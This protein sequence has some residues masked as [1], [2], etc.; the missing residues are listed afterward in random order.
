[1][2]SPDRIPPS[3]LPPGRWPWQRSL[4]NRIILG[5]G[6]ILLAVLLLLSVL[7]GQITYTTQLDAAEH[8]LELA[9]FLTANA[10][11]D[12]LS[13]FKDEFT[14]YEKWENEKEKEKVYEDDERDE[15]DHGDDSGK[16]TP[17]TAEDGAPGLQQG[18][19][20]ILPRLQQLAVLAA[21]DTSARVTILDVR[22]NAV[23]DSDYPIVDITNQLQQ[24]EVQTAITGGEQYEVREEPLSG[25]RRLYAAAPIQQGNALLGIVQISRPTSEIMKAI[26]NVEFKLLA[27]GL[28]ALIV[29]VI[30]G[31]WISRRLVR[32]VNELEAAAIA[33]AGG[34]FHYQIEITRS[35]ELGALA[36]AFNHMV[37]ELRRMIEQQRAFVADA[38]HELR[39]PLTNI[40]LRSEALLSYGDV[41]PEMTRRYLVEIDSEADRLA[42]LATDLLD[43]SRL[44]QPRQPLRPEQSIEVRPMVRSVTEMMQLRAQQKNVR[45]RTNLSDDLPP[46]RIHPEH[47]E[48][49]LVNLIDNAIKYTPAGGE[50]LVATDMIGDEVRLSVQDSG[51]GIPNAD[52]PHIFDPF[53]RVD[54]AR[55]RRRG[56]QDE[57]GSGAGL[58][59]SIVKTLVE[60]NE[61]RI[62]VETRAEGSKFSV[63][64]DT[65]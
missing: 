39:T 13:G 28:V 23:A 50:V 36:L 53:Y 30:L 40:K 45:L 57:I 56:A 15:E 41:E 46:L 44:E 42:R 18:D 35:D 47:L 22:G 62:E 17:T 33:T 37:N 63:Y 27:A 12:P 24:V 14:Q 34:D 59:L 2:T 19:D 3:A 5:Y 32:P 31:L 60:Q 48:A 9:A 58:G 49:I 25:T 11:E 10:L 64:F 20:I 8:D 52:L 54:K 1:M 43:L 38:S 65:R 7:V 55:S 6:L 21:S 29:S 16:V 51:P 61:G 26:W 4:Q